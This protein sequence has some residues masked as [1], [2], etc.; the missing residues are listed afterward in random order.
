[1]T[2]RVPCYVVYS[3]YLLLV[4][5]ARTELCFFC[6]TARFFYRHFLYTRSVYLCVTWYTPV[7][8]TVTASDGIKLQSVRCC[9]MVLYFY[10]W[11]ALGV[12]RSYKCCAS[13]AHLW[14][15]E[16]II[17]WT[18]PS[19]CA[20]VRAGGGILRLLRRL[21]NSTTLTTFINVSQKTWWW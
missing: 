15:T 21:H 17:F 11:F 16:S 2:N 20:C 9:V 4:N 5:F 6:W 10:R 7:F 18:C 13:N 19:V 3:I 14:A 12:R 8:F 1:M